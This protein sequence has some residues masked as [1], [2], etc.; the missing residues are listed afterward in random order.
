LLEDGRIHP[1]R[2][3]E[4][5]DEVKEEL[6][7]ASSADGEALAVECGATDLNPA[8]HRTLGRLRFHRVDGRNLREQCEERVELAGAMADELALDGAL[9]RRI[10]LLYSLGAV[11]DHDIEGNALDA[12]A[13]LGRRH[14]EKAPVVGALRALSRGEPDTVAAVLVETAQRLSEGRPGARRA[15]M[16]AA[17]ERQKAMESIGMRFQGVSQAYAIQA[18]RELRVMVS[19]TQVDDAEALMLSRDIAGAIREELTFPG[20]VRVTVVRESRVSEVAR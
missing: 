3:E 18:G 6:A 11:S 15:T 12:A 7:A 5:V 10:A 17:V 14:G 1:A 2:I 13:E 19:V 16:H 8:L 4:V 20:E 9:T